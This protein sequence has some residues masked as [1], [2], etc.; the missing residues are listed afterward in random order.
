MTIVEEIR[1]DRESGARRLEAEY[2][3]GLMT[4]AR[5]FCHDEGDAEELVNH[6]FAVVVDRIDDYLE[7]SAFFA[8]MCQILS[9]LHSEE[10]RRK[11]N[12]TILYPGEVPDLA[13]EAAEDRIYDE[14]DASLVRDAVDG[15]P[16]EMRETVVLHYFTGLSVPQIAKFLAIPAGT[17]KS[18]LHY[19]RKALAA[20]FSSSA[21]EFAKKP[22]GKALLLALLLC[23]ITALGAVAGLAVASLLSSPTVA[24]EQQADNSKD[25]GQAT[26]D[27]RQVEASNL[28]TFQPFNFSTSSNLPQSSSATTQ[29]A[30]ECHRPS[31]TESSFLTTQGENMNISRTAKTTAILAYA[32]L[33]LT[34]SGADWYVAPGGTGGG[35]SQSDRGDLMDVFYNGQVASG[36]TIHLAAGTYNLDK[37]KSPEGNAY[38]AGAYISV[39]AATSSL[40]FIGES[41]YPEAVRLIGGGSTDGMRI[42][43]FAS[44]GHVLQ[45]LLISG[46]YATYQGA[47]LCM[48]DDFVGNPEAAFM[49]SNCVVENCS[50]PYTG[51]NFGGLWRNCVIRNNEVRNLTPT[52][53]PNVTWNWYESIE[54][55][56]GGVFHATLYDCVVT[57]NVAGFCGGGI[58]GGRVNGRSDKAI[59]VTKAYNCLI[60]WNRAT[61]GGGAGAAPSYGTRDYVQLFGCTLVENVGAYTDPG[62]GGGL[63]GG[64]YQCVVSNCVVSGNSTTRPHGYPFNAYG[65]DYE[66]SSGG[67][68][69]DCEVYDS[70]IEGSTSQNNGAGAAFSSLTRCKILNN[71]A[72][73]THPNFTFGGGTYS[74]PQVT[75][76]VLSGNSAG[77]GGAAYS[78]YLEN[79][80]ISNNQSTAYDGGATYDASTRNCLVVGNTAQRYYAV[81]KG[82]HYG[83]LVYG[84][85]NHSCDPWENLL[86]PAASGIGADEGESAVAVNCTVWNNIYSSA[87][88]S[89]TTLTNSIV[90]SVENIPSAVNSFWRYG[91][92]ENQTGC[93]SGE[94][95]DPLFEGIQL[96]DDAALVA[97]VPPEAYMIKAGSPCRDKGLLLDGQSG[98]KDLLGNKRVKYYGVD[99][100]A[101]ECAS[102]LAFTIVIQ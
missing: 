48:A 75:D 25:A 85:T 67:G 65:H 37:S 33:A 86:N 94:D 62:D 22:G 36:D 13:D 27:A 8:W 87:Q 44:G 100:G 32:S 2:K 81:C 6:T 42:F 88:V 57:N 43:Y 71:T 54:G 38:G 76:C 28:S 72:S 40:T 11:S 63:G 69:M 66:K 96:S 31:A 39:P 89:R 29:S 97:N 1:Q 12:K 68:V 3:A 98:E 70:T 4:L 51:S 50:A 24:E 18:R 20:K 45:N 26:G 60:G 90:G 61:Y 23:G 19:A 47:G 15:L 7:K 102:V 82:T 73:W 5:R 59:C 92:V 49:A 21:H 10:V 9:H 84:N 17:V 14:V 80:V 34:G 74:C 58:A 91:T 46:G 35:T 53:N 55:S 79:C 101:L 93:I 83:T 56:G 41:D 64:A 99:M 30:T 95:K 16:A 78:G 77:Y 52:P